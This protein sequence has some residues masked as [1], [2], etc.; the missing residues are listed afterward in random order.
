M[1]HRTRSLLAALLLAAPLGGAARATPERPFA[2]GLTGGETA[3]LGRLLGAMERTWHESQPYAGAIRTSPEVQ[4]SE[5]LRGEVTQVLREHFALGIY[6]ASM[7]RF[8]KERSPRLNSFDASFLPECYRVRGA[9]EG[10][11]NHSSLDRLDTIEDAARSLRR[12]MALLQG[13]FLEFHRA[14]LR[15]IADVDPGSLRSSD[16]RTAV[17]VPAAAYAPAR[18]GVASAAAEAEWEA[19]TDGMIEESLNGL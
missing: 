19:R 13:Q 2:S 6:L 4:T 5:K 12:S 14:Y 1:P 8:L 17:R 9:L 7:R 16:V 3:A 18:P 10:L 15:A 11:V